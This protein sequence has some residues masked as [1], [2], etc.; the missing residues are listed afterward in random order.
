MG[1]FPENTPSG[2][3]L[4]GVSNLII[5]PEEPFLL[6][7]LQHSNM[8]ID[9]SHPYPDLV[10][11]TLYITAIDGAEQIPFTLNTTVSQFILLCS[12]LC[13]MSC[14]MCNV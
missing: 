14:V 7:Y 12:G 9:A 4:T 13:N 1:V 5:Q 3:G 2:L 10:G 8:P 11:V 6:G